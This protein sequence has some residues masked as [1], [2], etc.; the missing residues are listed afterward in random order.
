[1][2]WVLSP[3]K[4]SASIGTSAKAMVPL[5]GNCQPAVID[6]QANTNE[7][8]KVELLGVT[9]MISKRFEE[10]LK[11]NDFHKVFRLEIID[12]GLPKDMEGVKEDTVKTVV[13]ILSGLY[14]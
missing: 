11:V 1:M 4:I 12:V 14:R 8:I 6:C 5:G 9:R 3:S 10:V 13:V 7:M 2:S